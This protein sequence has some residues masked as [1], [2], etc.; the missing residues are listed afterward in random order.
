MG[1][2]L[3]KLLKHK[4]HMAK[5]PLIIAIIIALILFAAAQYIITLVDSTVGSL[6][7]D[8]TV[9]A[10]LNDGFEHDFNRQDGI[11]TKNSLS[12]GYAL[13]IDLDELTD[14]ILKAL[15]K[16]D[17]RLI[18]YFSD[19]SVHEN[20]KKMIKAGYITQYPDLR[21][22]DEIWNEVPEGEFQ[23]GIKFVR[24]KSD[25]NEIVLQYIPLGEKD[26]TE[27]NTLNGL[28]NQAN[29]ISNDDVKNNLLKYFSID[30][31]GNLVI[32]NWN[33]TTTKTFNGEYETQYVS[34]EEEVDYS[35]RD[36]SSSDNVIENSNFEYKLHSVNYKSLISKYSMPFNYLWS[37]LVYGRDEEFISDFAELILDSKIEI[38]IYDNLVEIESGETISYNENQ[39]KSTKTSKRTI[40]DNKEETKS[41]GEWSVPIQN[42]T[43]HHYNTNYTYTYSNS[44]E[45]YVTYLDIWYM[46]Y[47]ANY[48]YEKEDSGLQVDKIT[49]SKEQIE[50]LNGNN[51]EPQIIEGQWV[52]TST[53]SRPKGSS[54][55]SSENTVLVQE[56][57]K[58]DSKIETETNQY[59]QSILYRAI[60]NKYTLEGNPE[61]QEKNNK[62]LKEG[63]IGYPNFCTLY[64]NSKKARKNITG[65]E[66]WLFEAIGSNE[67]TVNMLELTKYMLYCA[68]EKDYGITSYNFTNLYPTSLVKG[69]YGGSVEEQIWFAL[70]D[71]GY[72]KEATAGVLGNLKQE[73]G[74]RSNNLENKYEQSLEMSDEQYTEAVD[75]GTYLNFTK[76]KAGYGLAQWTSEGRKEGLYLYSKD[77][78][79][80][81]SDSSMQIQYLLGEI[82]KTG[83][84]NGKAHF[85]MGASKDGCTYDSW[86]TATTP[87]DA[88]VAFCKVYE[89][90]G[91]EKLN[92]RKQYAKEAYEKYKD[93]EKDNYLIGNIELKG[94]N[95]D[96]MLNL[97]SEAI[98]IANDDRYLYSQENRMG[99]FTYDCSSLVYRLYKKHFGIEV[100]LTTAGYTEE[101][102]VGEAT[103]VDLKPGDV[104]WYRHG[105]KGHVIIYL[106]NGNYVAARSDKRPKPQQIEVYQDNPANYQYVYRF[107]K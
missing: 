34:N 5:I 86:L 74:I 97:L 8:Y 64:A 32:V 61:V 10:A 66:E 58:I 41:E 102:R 78:N 20:L 42:S 75:N 80:S 90:A 18:L 101:Y 21:K 29:E 98:N 39:L 24:H 51:N 92:N 36:S 60:K 46:K 37:F 95:K 25:G 6:V 11:N 57:E 68:V 48:A 87:E 49:L 53:T 88:A 82:S 70:I 83:G 67:D 2:M 13:D 56:Q 27:L 100:P 84:A 19:K 96:K 31:Q 14:T 76:D 72:S 40:V 23:G 17:K 45:G 93:A 33:K 35:D 104:L 50:D 3:K 91:D 43:K 77:L 71:A 44:I 52:T 55:N 65:V 1:N 22:A 107:I 94:E 54:N 9:K 30:A 62:S 106:G 85:Q 28:I 69:L 7:K 38:S 99:W 16:E 63:D 4:L 103:Q 81:I 73:S 26:S 105:D 15:I 47:S 59:K 12:G 89:R 79:V